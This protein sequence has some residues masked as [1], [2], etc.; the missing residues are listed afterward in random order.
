M[1]IW[2]MGALATYAWACLFAVSS[3]LSGLS[4]LL[5]PTGVAVRAGRSR[6]G[7][8]FCHDPLSFSF[9]FQL[10]LR[11]NT[12]SHVH[13]ICAWWRRSPPRLSAL[14]W[15]AH[16]CASSP[17]STFLKAE[18]LNCARIIQ[19]RETSFTICFHLAERFL[20]VV[21][22]IKC[23]YH[24]INQQDSAFLCADV[25]ITMA[26]FSEKET[27]VYFKWYWAWYNLDVEGKLCPG[28][29]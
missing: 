3:C 5:L 4:E 10:I 19:C 12:L 28:K 7:V 21:F 18:T 13:L 25:E 1:V 9:C 23:F 2:E 14:R 8:H 6:T 26:N 24:D 17:E 11:T 29:Q 27:S 20:L 16:I 15:A 22:E